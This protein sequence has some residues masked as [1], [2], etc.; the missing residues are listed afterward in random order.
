MLTGVILGGQHAS[1]IK[2]PGVAPACPTL[3][4]SGS[5]ARS[6]KSNLRIKGRTTWYEIVAE[7][8][9]LDANPETYNRRRPHCDCG[10]EGRTP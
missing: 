1:A 10:M 3:S 9:D 4:S 8:E 2:A 6:S 5:T 7:Q